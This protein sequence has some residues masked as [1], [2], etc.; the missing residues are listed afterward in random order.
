MKL[1]IIPF[2]LFSTIAIAIAI[3]IHFLLFSSHFPLLYID[4]GIERGFE[5]RVEGSKT[6]MIFRV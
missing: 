6:K 4:E 2:V 1:E 5:M 3:V